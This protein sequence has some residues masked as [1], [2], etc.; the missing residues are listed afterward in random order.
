MMSRKSYYLAESE[1]G[2]LIGEHDEEHVGEDIAV[3]P[4]HEEAVT[5]ILT[6][7]TGQF[8]VSDENNAVLVRID[9]AEDGTITKRD[10]SFEYF[11]EDDEVMTKWGK[12]VQV[13]SD[14]EDDYEP[15]CSSC[16]DG[17]CVHCEPSRFIEGYIY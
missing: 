17:G 13:K 6:E 16:G 1:N 11:M 10:F 5:Y 12:P 14:D 15:D 3:L 9:K 2:F 8:K 4:T 7:F